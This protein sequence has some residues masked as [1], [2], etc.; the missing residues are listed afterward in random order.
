[1]GPS[2]GMVTKSQPN[3]AYLCEPVTLTFSAGSHQMVR[4]RTAD[5]IRCFGGSIWADSGRGRA[6]LFAMDYLRGLDNAQL[7]L[8]AS[9]NRSLSP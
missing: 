4:E 3:A 5:P 8:T 1:M 6:P 7:P 2:E 9:F